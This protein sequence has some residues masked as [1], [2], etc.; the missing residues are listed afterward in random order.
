VAGALHDMLDELEELKSLVPAM[1]RRAIEDVGLAAVDLIRD[2]WPR[3]TGLSGDSWAF[4]RGLLVIYNPV[5]YVSFVHDGLAD[6][7]VPAVLESLE[8][9]FDQHLER[10]LDWAA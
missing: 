1:H 6:R 3:L 2:R 7:L 9:D 8:P 4:D 10:L 5:D